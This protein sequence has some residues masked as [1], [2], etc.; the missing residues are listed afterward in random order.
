MKRFVALSIVLL[1]AA[2]SAIADVGLV[3]G[4]HIG[5][6]NVL[7]IDGVGVAQSGIVGSVA[8]G[9]QAFDPSTG[10]IAIQEEAGTLVEVGTAVSGGGKASV[11]QS[12][13][14]GALQGLYANDDAILAGQVIG[15]GLNQ[16]VGSEGPAT[17]IGSEGVIGTQAQVVASP[18]GVVVNYQGIGGASFAATSTA[19]SEAVAVNNLD[20]YAG[21]LT[22]VGDGSAPSPPPY[23]P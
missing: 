9:Q 23:D 1:F 8:H 14:I 3:E 13:G 12:G 20:V 5:G 21:Q 4:F 18:T 16:V 2:T 17:A 11:I 10:T 15:A 6:T 22:I 19:G 7:L